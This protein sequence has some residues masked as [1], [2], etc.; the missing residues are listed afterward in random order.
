[1]S[2]ISY[3]QYEYG[4]A[5]ITM[6]DIVSQELLYNYNVYSILYLSYLLY[7]CRAQDTYY[8]T[9]GYEHVEVSREF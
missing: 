7:I 2:L 1:M 4:S 9:I 3:C 5:E 6:E 8:H